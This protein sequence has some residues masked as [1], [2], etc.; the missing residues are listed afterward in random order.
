MT[1]TKRSTTLMAL[2]LV[3]LI[4][5]A[6]DRTILRPQGGPGAASAASGTQSSELLSG[7]VPVL[8]TQPSEPGVAQR[9]EAL[10]SGEGPDF[11]RMRNPFALPATWIEEPVEAAERVPDAVARFMR[12][13]Q[14]TAIVVQNEGSY[15]L[16]ND[17]LLAPGRILDGFTL[18]EVRDRAAV[19]EQEGNQVLLEL[20]GK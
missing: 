9:L 16:V 3:G 1:M 20:I 2:F 4:A 10:G 15:A 12:T 5:L 19:F 8:E 18:V 17:Q 13:H 7:N 11:E 14:L 6:A